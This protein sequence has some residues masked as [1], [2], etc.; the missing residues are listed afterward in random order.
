MCVCRCFLRMSRSPSYKTWVYLKR[1]E[2]AQETGRTM[3]Y[4]DAAGKLAG[5]L[6]CISTPKAAC[7]K[8]LAV[9][10]GLESLPSA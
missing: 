5:V 10:T 2:L 7:C 4:T 3:F 6:A 8:L 1:N 9:R